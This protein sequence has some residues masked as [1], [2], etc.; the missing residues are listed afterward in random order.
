MIPENLWE[1]KGVDWSTLLVLVLYPALVA[2]LCRKVDHG[3]NFRGALSEV[4]GVQQPGARTWREQGV[5]LA[6][7][8]FFF[9]RRSRPCWGGSAVKVMVKQGSSKTCSGF[10]FFICSCKLSAVK[11]LKEVTTYSYIMQRLLKQSSIYLQ[12]F[13]T[14]CD[15]LN[16]KI[17]WK[18]HREAKS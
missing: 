4:Q 5:V 12:P 15:H 1:K 2:M 10:L 14:T 9:G 8:P 7:D 3:N 16:P 6:F 18:G 13:I 11:T 17:I